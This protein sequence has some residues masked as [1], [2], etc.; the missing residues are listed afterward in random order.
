MFHAHTSLHRAA[1]RISLQQQCTIANETT[2][3]AR[4]IWGSRNGVIV[5]AD[6]NAMTGA[7]S[8]PFC[9]E[10]EEEEEEAESLRMLL[11]GS[12]PSATAS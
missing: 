2:R 7:R 3:A 10:E 9:P 12:S 11:T 4:H 8:M 1:V 5:A 6:E